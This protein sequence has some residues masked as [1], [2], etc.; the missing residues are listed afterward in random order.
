MRY[1]DI[2]ISNPDTKKVIRT[3]ST[4]KTNGDYNPSGLRAYFDLPAN[5]YAQLAG[6]GIVRLW[7]VSYED[8][9]HTQDLNNALISISVGM[10][11]GLPLAKPQQK[12]LV[13]SGY[14][15]QAFG[16]WQGT[17]ITLDLIV[18]NL[19][20]SEQAANLT[21]TCAKGANIKNSI[22]Q[23]LKNAYGKQGYTVDGESQLS[24][25]LIAKQDLFGQYQNIVQ[26]AT[27][28]YALGKSLNP[29]PTYP[30]VNITTVG[31]VFY[32]WDST[33]QSLIKNIEFTDMIGNATWSAQGLISFKTVMR[34]DLAVN[35]YIQM[36]KSSNVINVPN[37]FSQFRNNVS[38]PNKFNIYSL[39]HLGDS[40]QPDA[41]SWCTVVQAQII[42]A[43]NEQASLP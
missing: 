6:N 5:N 15:W 29:D 31:T 26:F 38:F 34:A 3:F 30:S 9:T 7:G 16:N 39:R 11:Q 8:L 27:A 21:F 17:E 40:R 42:N 35:Q 12:G 23:T 24:S 22:V 1:Y 13:F 2:T 32:L 36:P 4:L 14:V 18:S 20:S 43:I 25:T 33:K 10:S 41:D 28:M 19:T 37:S